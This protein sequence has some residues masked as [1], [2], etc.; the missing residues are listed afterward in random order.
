MI[1]LSHDISLTICDTPPP[2]S[3]REIH[4]FKIEKTALISLIREVVTIILQKH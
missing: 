2:P 4:I 3:L 1:Y